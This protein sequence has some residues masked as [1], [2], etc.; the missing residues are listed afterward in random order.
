MPDLGR[1]EAPA[2]HDGDD[3]VGLVQ[4]LQRLRHRKGLSGATAG[5]EDDVSVVENMV[6]GAQIR[7]VWVTADDVREPSQLLDVAF[8]PG[9]HIKD[10][11]VV[12]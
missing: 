9:R 4:V 10:P 2:I 5:L 3:F 8:Q 6:L 1:D 7:C 12:K 11:M